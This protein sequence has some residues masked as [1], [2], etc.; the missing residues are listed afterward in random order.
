MKDS[1]E[2]DVRIPSPIKSSSEHSSINEI[3][4][5]LE[6]AEDISLPE[7]N[8]EKMDELALVGK[9]IDPNGGKKTVNKSPLLKPKK[10]GKGKKRAMIRNYNQKNDS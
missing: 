6:N 9:H 2:D 3:W 5:L 10:F 4:K 1:N 7:S 8:A